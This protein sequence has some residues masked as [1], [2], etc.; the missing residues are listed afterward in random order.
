MTVD[1]EMA[2]W[3]K[4][5]GFPQDRFPQI[6]WVGRKSS[7]D[8]TNWTCEARNF[9]PRHAGS[10]QGIHRTGN[11]EYGPC[12][13]APD[14]RIALEWLEREKGIDW[15]RQSPRM[16]AVKEHWFAATHDQKWVKGAATASGLLLEIKYY[17]EAKA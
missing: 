5:Q 7:S 1:L 17:M 2:R 13:A 12:I 8:S 6:V 4:E 16:R 14:P 3:L 11:I 9:Q 15:W 10:L